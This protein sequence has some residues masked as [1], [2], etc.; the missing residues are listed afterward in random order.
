[1]T[2]PSD[3][4]TLVVHLR[5][6]RAKAAPAAR[7]EAHCVLKPLQ[8]E[9]LRGGPLSDRGGVFWVRTRAPADDVRAVDY[10]RLGYSEAVDLLV[11]IPEA[12]FRDNRADMTRFR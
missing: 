10:P 7:L 2:D 6:A 11:P 5:E 3:E 9:L 1:M 8:P 12:A 4:K